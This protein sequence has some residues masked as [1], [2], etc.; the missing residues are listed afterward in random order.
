MRVGHEAGRDAFLQALG[1]L[2]AAVE[3]LDD[4]A[5]V[6]ASRCRGWT[7]GDVLVHVH[8]GLQECL[9]GLLDPTGAAPDTDAAGYWRV[10]LPTN[11]TGA[12][13]L[14]GVRFVRLL[15]AAYRRPSGVVG[16]L[17]PTVRGVGRAVRSLPDGALAFQGRV[18]LTGDFLATWA[19]ELAVHHLDLTRELDLAAPAPAALALARQTVEALAG[20]PLP[21]DWDDERAVLIG[22]GRRPPTAAEGTQVGPLPHP[23][24][25][26]G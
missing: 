24:P 23:L 16:H 13:A 10:E 6:A 1:A 12:D 11:D 3:G 22:T 5:F 19:V 25:V 21:P 4:E 20:G 8:L 18:L 2:L 14:A 17:R 15:G 9:L 7:V 26:L